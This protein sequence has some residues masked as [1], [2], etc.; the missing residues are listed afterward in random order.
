MGSADR[1]AERKRREGHRLGKKRV[2]PAAFSSPPNYVP[3]MYISPPTTT[4][5][6]QRMPVTPCSERHACL[7]PRLLPRRSERKVSHTLTSSSRGSAPLS[8]ASRK[9]SGASVDDCGGFACPLSAKPGGVDRK[10]TSSSFQVS[11]L[12]R[13]RG[14]VAGAEEWKN[15]VPRAGSERHPHKL[16]V[17]VHEGENNSQCVYH[18][19]GEARLR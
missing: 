7:A 17:L 14:N 10:Q 2:L 8:Q 16:F 5:N 1:G 12:C 15:G 4:T 19:I 3:G 13:Y 9:A 6:K 18:K 11:L